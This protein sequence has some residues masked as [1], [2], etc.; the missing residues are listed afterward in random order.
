MPL[1]ALLALAAFAPAEPLRSQNELLALPSG[2]AAAALLGEFGRRFVTMVAEDDGRSSGIPVSFATAPESAFQSGLCRAEVLHFLIERV[3][4]AGGTPAIWSFAAGQVYKAVGD[5]GPLD[6]G[7]EPPPASQAQLCA[8]AGPVLPSRGSDEHAP[9]FFAYDGPEGPWFA[10]AALRTAISAARQRRLRRLACIQRSVPGSC[11]DPQASVA[12][13]DL[14]DL[15][16]VELAA[17]RDELTV[18]YRVTARFVAQRG[19]STA[20]QR[21]LVIDVA[22]VPFPPLYD[23]VI[24]RRGR[25]TS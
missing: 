21:E 12:A 1:S 15:T 13:L 16:F 9:R 14:G 5:V 17:R 23:G 18:E 25:F 2:E 19:I 20:S 22:G 7:D 6:R 3:G 8:A 11:D 10:L 24:V 4:P